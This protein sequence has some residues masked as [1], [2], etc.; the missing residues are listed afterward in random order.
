MAVVSARRPGH[1]NHATR[2]KPERDVARLSIIESQI[3]E[4]ERPIG[5]DQMG[6]PKIEPAIRQR[7]GALRRVEGH[8]HY[9]L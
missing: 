5:N 1:H 4:G 2:Q 9:F 7:D 6:I 8:D 3:F